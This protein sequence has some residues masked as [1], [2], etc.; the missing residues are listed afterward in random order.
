MTAPEGH[1]ARAEAQRVFAQD[2][3][4]RFP[5]LHALAEANTGAKDGI[6][7]A[8]LMFADMCDAMIA[9]QINDADQTAILSLLEA[10]TRAEDDPISNLIVLGFLE[11]ISATDPSHARLLAKLGPNL[12]A[13]HRRWWNDG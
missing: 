3:A 7:L 10:N 12:R 8:N 5:C 4:A 6:L 9:D 13:R 2:L 1:Q 11:Y